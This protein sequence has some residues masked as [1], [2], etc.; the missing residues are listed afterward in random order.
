MKSA[1]RSALRSA[2][3]TSLIRRKQLWIWPIL[4][5]LILGLC[6]WWVSR[7]VENAMRERRIGELTAI[8]NADVAALHV[9]TLE[10]IKDALLIADDDQ[11]IS[12][13]EQLA[14]I[15][16]SAADADPTRALLQSPAQESIRARLKPEMALG[17]AGFVI[18]SPEAVVLAADLDAPVGRSL[19]GYQRQFFTQVAAGKPG[20]SHPFRSIL[21]LKDEK[22]EVKSN[23]PTMFTAAPLKNAQGQIVAVLGLRIRPDEDFTRILQVARSGETGETYAFNQDG[24]MLSESRFD[25]NLKQIGLL[26]DLPDSRSILT[27]EMRDPGVD[28]TTGGR[29]ELRRADQPLTKMATAALKR[30]SGVEVSG[31]RDYRGVPVI[32]A[33]TWLKD[34]GFG[35][36]TKQ[37]VAESFQP[38]YVLRRAFWG[39]FALLVIAAV[40]IFFFTVVVAHAKRE[41]RLAALSAKHLGQYTLDEKLGEGGMGIVYRAHHDMLHRP[42]A[43]KFLG[44]ERTNE[45]TI[46]RFER[47]VQLTS[48]LTHPNTI[49]IYDYGRTAEG[50]FYY[51]MEY[52]DG[53]NLEDLVK[54]HGAQPEGR[55]IYILQQVCGSLAEAHGTE[56]IHRDIKPANIILTE[57]GGIY[58]FVKLLDFGLVKAL[59]DRKD[60]SLTAT[61]TLTGTPLYM[62]P[63]AIQNNQMDARSDL[64]AVGA[65]GYFLLTG[66]PVFDADN[67]IQIL[68]KH[69]MMTPDSPAKR[70]GK[71]VSAEF[72]ALLLKCLEKKPTDRPA[73]A[74]ALA[75]LLGQCSALATWTKADAY[76]WWQKCYPRTPSSTTQPDTTT[77]MFDATQILS[78]ALVSSAKSTEGNHGNGP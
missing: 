2:V 76:A 15:G 26:A 18:L 61:G 72:E 14:T 52:L 13:V 50:I 46:A 27:L 73:S 16:K 7:S 11:L 68:Q 17:Y 19:P 35:V 75:D 58:D 62:P 71:P 28:M 65:V 5:T 49:A 44:A 36:T 60:S 31:F 30:E 48:K 54:K 67:V 39:M 45:Q 38:L 43:V 33:W 66:T 23:L 42:T 47:E 12:P 53:I 10:E 24:L 77:Q 32:S 20:V 64:Y 69:V 37:D 6:G 29:P 22:G 8:L 59:D 51:A 55:V 21:L 1:A 78:S 70:L 56:L 9:W 57:R 41:A 4:A 34:E 3:V 74:A 63:E 40:A 25:D